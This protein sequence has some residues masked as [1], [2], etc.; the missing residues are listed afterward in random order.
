M[1]KTFTSLLLS[2]GL[3]IL[4][5]G[6]NAPN[7]IP[8]LL[9]PEDRSNVNNTTP[10]FNW[11]GTSGDYTIEFYECTPSP[12]S[13]ILLGNYVMDI[14]PVSVPGTGD[15][16]GLAYNENTNTLFGI[17]NDTNSI[18]EL[19]TDGTVLR[20]ITLTGFDDTEAIT[21][22]GNDLFAIAEERRG[23]IVFVLIGT[24]SNIVYPSTYVQLTGTWNDNSGLEGLSYD[25]STNIMYVVQ[26]YYPM[27]IHAFEV[28]ADFTGT[29]TASNPFD[30]QNNTYGFTDL[31][32]LHHLSLPSALS[33]YGFTENLLIMS[34]L[35]AAV[36]EVNPI[37]GEEYSRLDLTTG[38]A[39][40]TVIF[41]LAQAEGVAVAP[42][43]NIYIIG[44]P[45]HFY[46]FSNSFF[47]YAPPTLSTLIHS[48]VV[49][50]NTYELPAGL[51]NDTETYCWR[52]VDNTDASVSAEWSF[53]VNELLP[54][55]L[56]RFE[57]NATDNKQ[58]RINWVTAS[59]INIEKFE[60]E[61]SNDGIDYEQVTSIPAKGSAGNVTDYEFFD[62]L[63]SGG[64]T[65]YRL[66]I[67]ETDGQT[68]Y[69][70]VQSVKV[71]I[72]DIT[73]HVFPNP[74]YK[75]NRSLVM[76]FNNPKYAFPLETEIMDINGKIVFQH[77]F[78]LATGYNAIP[79]QLN[80][81]IPGGVYI[82]RVN[83]NGNMLSKKLVL[84]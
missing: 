17:D 18:F 76:E 12:D 51:L 37:T 29:I 15:L 45:N 10:Q 39:N 56:T 41:S 53:T 34:Q 67:I 57:V 23:R 54:L 50:V 58:A 32:G 42:D 40:G 24:G 25:S 8:D 59:E 33:N 48:E 31:S 69:S 28:P 68:Y 9:L 79:V 14:G 73:F 26:E 71:D 4:L 20:T 66:K 75:N 63:L 44:E 52:V 81:A 16:S 43:G 74:V 64:T 82:I 60:L 72:G 62:Y 22:M 84:E 21:Y 13:T 35:N 27:T 2:T 5:S 1:L 3:L 49:S 47:P 7:S 83:K 77:T 46:R 61:R 80:D 11:N 6:Y 36:V 19:D 70:D 38:G 78:E 55:E 30:I 65:Y